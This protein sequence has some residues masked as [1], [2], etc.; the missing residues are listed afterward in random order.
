MGRTVPCICG[1]KLFD[2]E[3]FLRP[4]FLPPLF[5]VNVAIGVCRDIRYTL[6]APP[7]VIPNGIRLGVFLQ[8]RKRKR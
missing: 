8:R 3:Y 5:H 6:Q 2:D 1:Q 4:R 7:S